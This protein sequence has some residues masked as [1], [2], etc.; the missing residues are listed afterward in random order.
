MLENIISEVITFMYEDVNSVTAKKL[1]S[2]LYVTLGKYDIKEK[3][4]ELQKVC[5]SWEK[6]LQKFLIRKHTDGLS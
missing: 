3:S 1:E 5:N 4:T 6:D 2:A